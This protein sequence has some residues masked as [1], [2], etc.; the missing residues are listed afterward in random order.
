MLLDRPPSRYC[1]YYGVER[2]QADNIR[3]RFASSGLLIATMR[4]SPALLSSCP[5]PHVLPRGDGDERI[6]LLHAAARMRK[7]L[8]AFRHEA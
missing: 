7:P 2:R 6:L 3:L 1:K 8:R 4:R 5:L